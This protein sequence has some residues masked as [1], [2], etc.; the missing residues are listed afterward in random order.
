MPTNGKTP[1]LDMKYNVDYDVEILDYKEGE[2][3]YGPWH[4]YQ[5]KYD[6]DRYGHFAQ[7][8]LH[9]KLKDCRNGD[10]VTIRKEQTDKDGYEWI[11]QAENTIQAGFNK[12]V[13]PPQS[14]KC[15]HFT[16]V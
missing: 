5:M 8:D 15:S 11:V 12:P 2:N 1:I 3:N 14:T 13:Q 10:I 16:S 9:E 7:S 4:F 6:G